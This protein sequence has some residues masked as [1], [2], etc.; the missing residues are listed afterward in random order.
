MIVDVVIRKLRE[1]ILVGGTKDRLRQAIQALLEQ[2]SKPDSKQ[3]D[4]IKRRIR[5]LDKQIDRAAERLL[6]APEDLMD[7]LAPKLSVMKKERQRLQEELSS[8]DSQLQPK[9]VLAEVDA[10]VNRLWSFG[11]ELQKAKPERLRELLQQAVSRIEL[12]FKH[13]QRGKRM[14]CPLVSGEIHFRTESDIFG[15][16]NRGDWI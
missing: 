10:A 9:D 2:R 12:R 5:Q 1:A 4:R 13:V 6:T 7:I 14:E 11:D 16:V 15:S 8:L 3:L